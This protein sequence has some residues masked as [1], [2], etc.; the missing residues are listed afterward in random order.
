M[1]AYLTVSLLTVFIAGDSLVLKDAVLTYLT[2][3]LLPVFI[4]VDSL[5]LLK[6]AVLAAGA[7][8]VVVGWTASHAAAYSRSLISTPVAALRTKARPFSDST[9]LTTYF[10]ICSTP[11]V[12]IVARKRSLVILPKVQ[13]AG[14]G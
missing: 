11:R 6:D 1:L 14:Y 5:V 9:F 4:T 12:T 7:Q 8:K 3:S 2:V 10:D 13:V